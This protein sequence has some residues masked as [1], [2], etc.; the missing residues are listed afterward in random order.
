M[1]LLYKMS[2]LEHEVIGR[3]GFSYTKARKMRE[4]A[5]PS[6]S[7]GILTPLQEA[8]ATESITHI[9]RHMD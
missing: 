8:K 4:P 2:E 7:V 1:A 5:A 6:S 3:Y 9:R